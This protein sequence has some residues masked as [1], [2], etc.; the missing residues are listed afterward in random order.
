MP[1]YSL[2]TAIGLFNSAISLILVITVNK[3]AKKLTETSLW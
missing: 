3:I 2:S 1:D